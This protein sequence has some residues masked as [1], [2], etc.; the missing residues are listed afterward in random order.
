MSTDGALFH[1]R[2]Q[3]WGQDLKTNMSSWVGR[4][5]SSSLSQLRLKRLADDSAALAHGSEHAEKWVIIKRQVTEFQKVSPTGSSE[6][7]DMAVHGISKQITASI[8]ELEEHFDSC[9]KGI[10]FTI[11]T[12]IL[13]CD[14]ERVHQA[15]T[16]F[17]EAD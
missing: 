9:I 14:H 2:Y 3:K 7:I 15:K 8:V 1:V 11:T 16:L 12:G 13:F 5:M 17:T 4:Q 10:A 6:Y